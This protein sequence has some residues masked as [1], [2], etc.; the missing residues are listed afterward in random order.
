MLIGYCSSA[1]YAGRIAEIGFDYMELYGREI[2]TLGDSEFIETKKMLEDIGLEC[3]GFVGSIPP[4]VRICG[5]GYDEKIV[6][7]YAKKCCDR[8]AE[9]GILHV[10]IGSPL[11]RNL[12]EGFDLDV[13]RE[14][15]MQSLDIFCS[16]AKPNGLDI[17]FESVSSPMCNFI[18]LFPEAVEIV[19]QMRLDNLF[20]V[21][22]LYHVAM[23]DERLEEY[24][25]M[26][27]DVKH[28]HIAEKADYG[29]LRYESEPLYNRWISF[30][31]SKGYDISISME[32]STPDPAGSER[33]LEILRRV[34][35]NTGRRGGM[36]S[37]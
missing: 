25:D 27:G 8:G 9:L 21:L 26:L 30:L 12:P 19:E 37:T 23:M 4:S 3:R 36:D 7:E 35:R 32:I 29:Q 34:D 20:L 18:T 22:D 13:A 15:I 10:G 6:S 2:S 5:P 14:Q 17:L 24:A 31:K 1:K 33:S 16:A 28:L 11:S